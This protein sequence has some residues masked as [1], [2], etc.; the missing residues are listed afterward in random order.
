MK[1]PSLKKNLEYVLQN[2]KVV[3]P[4]FGKFSR[5]YSKLGHFKAMEYNVYIYEMAFI[6]K[7]RANLSPKYF[8]YLPKTN[9]AG[10]QTL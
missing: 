10:E 1:R 7:E 8:R 5:F 4:F 3:W 9:F 6:T 2:V